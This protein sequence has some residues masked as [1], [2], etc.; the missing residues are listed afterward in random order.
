VSL[1]QC[2][3]SFVMSEF[4][5]SVCYVSVIMVVHNRCVRA[6]VHIEIG[7]VACVPHFGVATL[8]KNGDEISLIIIKHD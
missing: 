8:N 4:R 6:S 2:M 7:Y 1:I 3:V 5:V